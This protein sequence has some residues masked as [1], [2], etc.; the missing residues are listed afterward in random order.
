MTLYNVRSK[1]TQNVCM[2][3]MANNEQ[4]ALDKAVQRWDWDDYAEYCAA[5]FNGKGDLYTQAIQ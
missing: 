4:E 2:T 3:I 5:S 1:I